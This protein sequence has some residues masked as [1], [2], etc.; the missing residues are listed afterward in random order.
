[1]YLIYTKLL[2]LPSNMCCAEGHERF[3][4]RALY[5]IRSKIPGRILAGASPYVQL[6]ICIWLE[7]TREI[8][9]AHSRR[10]GRSLT[11]C[12]P[13]PSGLLLQTCWWCT[14]FSC[15]IGAKGGLPGCE[16][17]LPE[18]QRK[19]FDSILCWSWALRWAAT[20]RSSS[21]HRCCW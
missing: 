17:P 5:V 15:C 13:Q 12:H 21:W 20:N 6:L 18:W 10:V 14:C 11:D 2:V 4:N 1:M 19:L 16:Q 8:L 3:S 9:L 7:P